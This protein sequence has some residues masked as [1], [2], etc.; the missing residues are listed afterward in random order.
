MRRVEVVLDLVDQRP[1][2]D[3]LRAQCER[4][5]EERREPRRSRAGSR[6]AQ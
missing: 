2:A 4:R 5:E 1:D 3:D 6:P